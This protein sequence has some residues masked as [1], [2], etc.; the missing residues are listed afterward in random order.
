MSECE[1]DN[2]Y[3]IFCRTRRDD[4]YML[5]Y[6]TDTLQYA[7]NYARKHLKGEKYKIVKIV[8]ETPS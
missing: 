5:V 6:D 3:A 7:K 8:E 4:I 2:K 1:F